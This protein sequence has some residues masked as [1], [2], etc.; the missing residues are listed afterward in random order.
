MRNWLFG[1]LSLQLSAHNGMIYS[2]L[3]PDARILAK[4]GRKRVMK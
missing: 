4:K 1:I 3:T 2:G